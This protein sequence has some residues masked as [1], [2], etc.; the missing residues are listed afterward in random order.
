[1]KLKGRVKKHVG[2]HRI[3]SASSLGEEYIFTDLHTVNRGNLA[4]FRVRVS[5]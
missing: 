1:M 4:R 5:I 3:V 2:L